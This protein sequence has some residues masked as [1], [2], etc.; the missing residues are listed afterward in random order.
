MRPD[1]CQQVASSSSTVWQLR[2]RFAA[3]C[4]LAAS[5]CTVD[6]RP[7]GSLV[8]ALESDLEIPKDI[9]EVRLEWSQDG[10]SPE[11][12]SFVL[13]EG[14]RLMPVERNVVYPGNERP[15]LIRAVALSQGEPR[16]ERSAITPIP[17]NWTG[18]LRLPLSF[19]CHGQV[20][21]SGESSCGAGETCKRGTCESAVL[22]LDEIERYGDSTDV[23]PVRVAADGGMPGSTTGGAD[24]PLDA[25]DG[26]FDV[27]TCMT[28]TFSVEVELESCAFTLPPEV[29][30]ERVNVA[31]R[32]P[33]G[34]PGICVNGSCFVVLDRG[35]EGYEI[36]N[37]RVLLPQAVCAQIRDGAALEVALGLSCY[38]K[39]ARNPA[40]GAWNSERAPRVQPDSNS[41]AV[42]PG[43]SVGGAGLAPGCAGMALQAC[44]MCGT[45]LRSCQEGQWSEWVV[46]ESQG[47]CLPGASEPCGRGGTRSCGGGCEWGACE[48]Q[49]C[50]GVTSRSCGNCGTET[51]RCL[52]GV[53]SEWSGC[54]G[55]GACMPG[56][57]QGCGSG[58]TQACGGNCQW[59]LCG[60]QSCPGAPTQA[61][62]NCGTSARECDP[63]RGTWSEF[64]AC[65]GTGECAPDA[66]RECGSRGTR[67]CRGDC[68]WDTACTGQVCEGPSTRA[69]DNCGTQTRTCDSDTGQ[70]SEW[71]A[72]RGQG[73]CSP[74]DTRECGR[75]GTRICGGNCRWSD[76]CTG[77]TCQGSAILEC[78]NCGVQTRSCDPN[79]GEWREPSACQRQGECSPRDPD[80]TAA[81]SC[82][83]RGQ[84]CDAQCHWQAC[85]GNGSVDPGERCDGN[86]PSSCP[87]SNDACSP[88]RLVGSRDSCDAECVPE[89]IRQCRNGDGCCAPGCN[90]NNDD[91]CSA[92]CGNGVRESGETCDRDCRTSCPDGVDSCHPQQLRGSAASCNVR[93]V[94][95]TITSCASGDGCCPSGCAWPMDMDCEEPPCG[96]SRIDSGETCD[97]GRTSPRRCPTSCGDSDACTTDVLRGSSDMCNVECTHTRITA[98][99]SGDGCCASGCAW[100]MDM[101][102]EQPPCGNGRIDPGE[103]CDNG[104]MSSRRCPTSCADDDACTMDGSRGAADSCNVECTHS[105]ITA[106]RSGD[107][108]CAA[109]CAWP[110]DMDC[111]QPTCGN[112]R[113]DMGETCDNGPMSSR[114][115][116]ASC[117]DDDAC[118]TDGSRG[119][120]DMCNVECTH[121][122]ITAC[123]SDDGCCPSACAWPMDMDCEQ[124]TCGNG[125]IDTGETCDNGPMSSRRCPASCA[126]DD[127]CTMDGSRGAAD[128]CNLEC[129]H[130]RITACRSGDGCCASGCAWPMD[131]DCEQPTCGNGR[132]D[133]GETCDNGPMSSRRCPATCADD[134]A[135]T[136]DGSRGAADSCNLEC[137]HSRITMCTSGDGCC[138]GSCGWPMDRD[139]PEPLCGN[140]QLD[141]GET[142]D[143]G[144]GPA[145]NCPASC[146][147]DDVC[148]T[149][150]TEGA[151]S[152]CNI[153]C[154]HSNITECKSADGCCPRG[155]ARPA[156]MDCPE[157]LC[158]N[159]KVDDGETCDPNDPDARC[160]T[161]CDDKKVC[162][163]DSLQGSAS[164]CTAR[165]V[166]TPVLLC[167]GEE[168]CC[169]SG[170]TSATDP[171]CQPPQPANLCGNG[172]EDPGETCDDGPGSP[173]PCD[174]TC[175]DD[176]PCTRDRMGGSADKCNVTCENVTITA[177]TAGDSCC[178]D[179]CG[180]PDDT[181]CPG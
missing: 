74:N 87:A 89:P 173:R 129:T 15:L 171:D 47:V 12:Q 98:C 164:A 116:P 38:T 174:K 16:I 80:N 102:C 53:W 150:R 7:A 73:E 155:C 137:T 18:Y 41:G 133:T 106:C 110:M 69:C 43:I 108:C 60:S 26:C 117:A 58:G 30:D 75:G 84:Y 10:R 123:R 46:C 50:E 67:T 111:E 5:G 24:A 127:A 97:N 36:S 167:G 93:C 140:G 82:G 23:N 131:M 31:L 95:E 78:G 139:C 161:A 112:G 33:L 32:L 145:P 162:T 37:G 147:D 115:C 83:A 11:T 57:T 138:P 146:A 1:L 45:Q 22:E 90:A 105:R 119:A 29:P 99:R 143:P 62:G 152:S 149:D 124:P 100:P 165:C 40:C 48:S 39:T 158:G 166:F 28:S 19:L 54:E 44:G 122:R 13:G 17:P 66:T 144:E 92:S 63:D 160:P 71:S 163:S 142:C 118:T 109:G 104:P 177:C 51:R 153:R 180:Y 101:D 3:L 154:S 128:S 136:T 2:L 65:T 86:C 81:R 96:N 169:P 168:G 88:L 114:R 79:S 141:T 91:D 21:E 61:C 130:S 77:Q 14:H 121:T 178:P 157:A 8:V 72:C 159:G 4:V 64:G 135:C 156:D 176:N 125:R 20:T 175:N 55:Q 9:D 42:T 170:C 70:W 34:R 56:A 68:T 179:N 59:G 151:A 172:V 181:D 103:T 113:I 85:C 107:G 6:N 49:T 27:A 94:V 126:D 132:I 25:D 120:A 35:V 52:N 148:T 76:A 134:D